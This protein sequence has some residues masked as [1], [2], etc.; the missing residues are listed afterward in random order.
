MQ[1]EAID[2]LDFA[3]MP[4]SA[5]AMS[6]TLDRRRL[7]IAAGLTLL[8]ARPGS[9][10]PARKTLALD[11]VPRDVLLRAG[12]AMP[13][14]RFATDI[15]PRFVRGD[16]V[17]V[18][19]ANRLPINVLIDWRGLDGV[20]EFEPLLARGPIAAG[21]SGTY[22]MTM[23]HAGTMICDARL[24]RDSVAQPLP[25]LPVVVSETM[26]PIADQDEV[27]L[28]EDWRLK[29]DGDEP[30]FTVNG[31]PLIQLQAN[32]GDRLRLRFINGTQNI[33]IAIQLNVGDV[34]VIAIDGQPSEPFLAREGRLVL[35]SGTRIDALVDVK[36][37][38]EITLA[39]GKRTVKIG[40]IGLSGERR[41][42]EPLPPVIA[43]S[44]NGLP[45]KLPLQSALRVDL[46]LDAATVWMPPAAVTA[47]TVPAFRVKRGRTVVLAL[48]NPTDATAVF[49]L[50]GHHMRLLD[51][52][53][54][55]WKPF[56]LDTVAMPGKQTVRV[57]FGASHPGAYLMETQRNSGRLFASYVIET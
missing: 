25:L 31:K 33:V 26:P 12:Q 40:E 9:A 28:I 48:A 52:L 15:A 30:T 50:H 49:H 44:S 21:A 6:L 24:T 46:N 35:A 32:V 11:L 45:D 19:I 29:S 7:L 42:V 16:A 37:A 47:A 23:R 1:G 27:V 3:A 20:P 41:K 13:A 22:A 5:S 18:T 2:R 51:R 57:A 56:W 34:R 36:A 55:G 43:L 4:W 53:D 54:D 14:W 8:G 17:D 10:A 38:G 39:D